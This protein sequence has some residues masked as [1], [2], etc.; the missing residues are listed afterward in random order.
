[1]G[2]S[3]GRSVTQW[4]NGVCRGRS[5]SVWRCIGD[6]CTCVCVG[7]GANVPTSA[8]NEDDVAIVSAKLGFRAD[9]AGKGRAD[10]RPTPSLSSGGKGP[11]RNDVD[12]L[13]C[14]SGS[15]GVVQGRRSRRRPT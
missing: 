13:M 10:V 6:M 1:M 2:A 7:L 9:E 8:N 12:G 3:Y 5:R 14:G 11:G 4:S 15:F